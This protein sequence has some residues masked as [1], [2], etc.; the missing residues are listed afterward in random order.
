MKKEN[1]FEAKLRKDRAYP[2]GIIRQH[3]LLCTRAKQISDEQICKIL[4]LTATIDPRDNHWWGKDTDVGDTEGLARDMREILNA[5][6]QGEPKPA[7]KEPICL[8][9]KEQPAVYCLICASPTKQPSRIY[10]EEDV[11]KVAEYN[12]EEHRQTVHAHVSHMRLLCWKDLPK[13]CREPE[14][15]KARSLLASLHLKNEN[16]VIAKLEREK[17]EDRTLN[18]VLLNENE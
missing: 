1:P 2:Q 3:R 11:E 15:N 13:H 7:Q 8:V 10:S 9:C 14:L 18:E 5:P 16:E 12:W 6:K 4:E 17:A